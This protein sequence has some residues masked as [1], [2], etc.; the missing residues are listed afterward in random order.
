MESLLFVMDPAAEK[1]IQSIDRPTLLPAGGS[2][3]RKEGRK[4]GRP[5]PLIEL[6][7]FPLLGQTLSKHGDDKKRG[8]Q[9]S[10]KRDLGKCRSYR[11]K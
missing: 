4:E 11:Y 10:R 7:L 5:S 3:R 2:M 9:P 8:G 6:D 1:P